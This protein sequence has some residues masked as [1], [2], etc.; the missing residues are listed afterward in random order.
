MIIILMIVVTK[1]NI[2]VSSTFLALKNI[3]PVIK[4]TNNP[5]II[6]IAIFVWI[7]PTARSTLSNALTSFTSNCFVEFTSNCFVA[8]SRLRRTAI[9]LLISSDLFFS[10][11]F[12]KTKNGSIK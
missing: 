9:W 1:P 4:A 6:A 3:I 10:I 8:F 7:N 5:N 12:S 11:L 2:I